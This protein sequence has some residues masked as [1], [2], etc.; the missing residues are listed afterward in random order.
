MYATLQ[1]NDGRPGNSRTKPGGR[2]E[3]DT[4]G[5]GG[6][7]ACAVCLQ[8]ITT[9]AARAVVNGRHN[10]VFCNPHGHVFDIS[11]FS[12]AANYTVAGPPS[13]EFTWFPGHT[14]EIIL[15][16]A[17]HTHLG[18]RFTNP[19]AGFFGIISSLLTEL[20]E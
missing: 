6:K 17:C 14:W 4:N 10:H 20:R 15:C 5:P 8:H 11:C 2:A 12:S 19:S 3:H 16:A 7:L 1:E 18:W 9:T 13:D